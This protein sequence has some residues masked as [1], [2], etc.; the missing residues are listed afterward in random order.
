MTIALKQLSG[1]AWTIRTTTARRLGEKASTKLLLP[2]G[3][4]LITVIIIVMVPTFMAMK[5]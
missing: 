3:I 4:S 1:E 5:L 2:M